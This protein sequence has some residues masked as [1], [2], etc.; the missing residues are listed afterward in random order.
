MSSISRA[1]PLAYDPTAWTWST[2]STAHLKSSGYPYFGHLLH[3]WVLALQLLVAAVAGF[4]HAGFA[5]LCPFIAEEV[6]AEVCV[7]ASH[8]QKSRDAF[9]DDEHDRKSLDTPCYHDGTQRPRDMVPQRQGW[10]YAFSPHRWI[11]YVDGQK[12]VRF[13]GGSYSNHAKFACWASA[14]FLVGALAG[15]VHGILPGVLPT[16][17]EDV[18]IELGGLIIKRRKL[19]NLV[20]REKKDSGSSSSKENIKQNSHQ[21]VTLVNPD[22]LSDYFTD[23][24]EQRFDEA[25][26]AAKKDGDVGQCSNNAL[27]LL[28]QGRVK[29][30]LGPGMG[31]TFL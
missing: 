28:A 1:G 18:A 2:D 22:N 19:R 17:C 4:I 10:P 13:S 27:S 23:E 15:F 29:V 21:E 9:D 30:Q 8:L 7:I 6:G 25:H 12:H 31:K 5:C 20:A 3:T 11:L 16:L 14:Q 24:F 26:A